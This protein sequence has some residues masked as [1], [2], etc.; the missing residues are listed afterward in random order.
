M[1][2]VPAAASL[3]APRPRDPGAEAAPP[4]RLDPAWLA[5]VAALTLLIG[6][7]VAVGADWIS[8]LQSLERA[9][10]APLADALAE[11]DPGYQLVNWIAAAMGWGIF[12]VNL[13]GGL[14]FSI[15]L[16]VFCRSL[17]RPWLALAV[18]VPYLVI[19]VA[20]GY[21]RQGIA[22]GLAMIGLVAL[23]REQAIRFTL[24]VVLAATFHKS[25]VLLLPIAALTARRNRYWS[26]AWVAVAALTAYYLLLEA[27]VDTLYQNYVEAQYESQGAFV[28]LA[29]NAMPATILILLHPRLRFTERSR[30]LWLWFAA[31]SLALLAILLGTAATTAVDRIALYVLPLQLVVFSHLPD[32][33][34]RTQ[35][36]P[37]QAAVLVYYAV[38][39]F[40][41]LN[42]ATHAVAWLPYR[43]FP[44]EAWP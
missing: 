42:F 13:V 6:Y 20:M 38:V 22:L 17:P 21:S 5:V 16:A 29:M 19:V 34:D 35:R 12:A 10:G 2:A 44:L 37:V 28:R 30:R 18:A 15:G 3:L 4:L 27:S 31:I 8:Y 1:F 43:F 11:G 23:G 36:G 14:L 40:V 39:L 33:F 26:T 32:A 9:A 41:W 25:A 24:W 7:R